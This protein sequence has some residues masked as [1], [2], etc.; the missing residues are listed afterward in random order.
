MCKVCRH[1]AGL[2]TYPPVS[3]KGGGL[4]VGWDSQANFS[5]NRDDLVGVERAGTF[6]M[7]QVVSHD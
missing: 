4:L 1:R 5:G 2:A 7:I 3:V 6:L